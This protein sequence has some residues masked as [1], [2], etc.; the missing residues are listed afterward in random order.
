MPE[1]PPTKPPDNSLASQPRVERVPISHRIRAAIKGKKKMI[2]AALGALASH[3]STF[4]SFGRRALEW[5]QG[6]DYLVTHNSAS[7]TLLYWLFSPRG[8]QLFT[9]LFLAAFFF[10]VIR[11]VGHPQEQGRRSEIRPTL[12]GGHT[13]FIIGEKLQDLDQTFRS[14]HVDQ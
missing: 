1:N 11:Y 7:A 13:D 12:V 5:L 9:G 2:A 4:F 14:L 3:F 8:A 10:L 6:Y